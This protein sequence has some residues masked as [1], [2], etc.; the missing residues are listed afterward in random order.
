M[1]RPSPET[2]P[3]HFRKVTFIGSFNFDPRSRGVNT[4]TGLVVDSS[5]LA[6]RLV[7]FLGSGIEPRNSYRAAFERKAAGMS[8]RFVWISKQVGRGVREFKDPQAG[9]R[10]R[11]SAWF[12][13]LLPIEGHV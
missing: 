4:E 10:R 2:F 7:E 5:E 1:A 12:I 3:P 11:L 9:F 8:G 6:E 13:S